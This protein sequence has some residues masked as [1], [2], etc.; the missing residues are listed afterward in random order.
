MMGTKAHATRCS[1]SGKLQPDD[2]R[3][4][5]GA[6]RR[7]GRLHHRNIKTLQDVRIGDTV[8]TETRSA[9]RVALPGYRQPKPMVFC[10]FY[11]TV[12]SDFENLRKAL[13][14]LR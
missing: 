8:C 7:R 11:P 3:A 12:P 14:K 4:G 5:E 10:G 6:A 9:R 1:R 13:E 2:A